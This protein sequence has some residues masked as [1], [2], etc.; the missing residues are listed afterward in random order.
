M[1]LNFFL[2]IVSIRHDLAERSSLTDVLL[3]S[4]LSLLTTPISIC[5]AKIIMIS[6]ET[7]RAV[8]IVANG[9]SS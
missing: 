1:S 5:H 3:I 7:I 6:L 9:K 2:D 4:I 8:N